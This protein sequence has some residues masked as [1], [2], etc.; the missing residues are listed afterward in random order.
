VALTR[1]G[2]GRSSAPPT[3]YE[4]DSL[5]EDIR[6]LLD[7]L[8]VQR[9]HLVGHS[10]AG[11]ELTRFATRHPERVGR[12][13]YLDAAYDRRMQL[14]EER[15]DPSTPPFPSEADRANWSTLLAFF[16]RPDQYYGRVWSAAVEADLRE[17]YAPGADGRLAD[18]TPGR[19]YGA[20]LQNAAAA[21]PDYSGI[22]MPVLSFYALMSAERLLPSDA[23]AVRRDSALAYQREVIDPWTRAS[24]AQLRRGVPGVRI[25]ELQDTYHHIFLHHP[26]AIAREIVAFFRLQA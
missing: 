26:V 9:A 7:T 18:R 3:G 20:I 4:P 1:R 24:E 13:V 23:P 19:V 17:R 11:V 6:V 5:A 15:P 21:S 10:L 8:G 14:A 22:R 16:Q 25:V 2:H 12:L